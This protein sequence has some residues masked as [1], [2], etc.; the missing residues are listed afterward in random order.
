MSKTY[1]IKTNVGVNKQI[2]VNLEQDF[3]FLEILSLKFRPEDIYP[4]S[5]SDFGLVTGRVIANGGYGVPNAK[6]SIFIPLS[7][8][9]ALNPIISALYPYK[10]ISDINEDGYRYNLLPYTSQ[11]GGH[12]PTGTFPSETDVLINNTLIE[13]YDK[14]Y[15]FTVKTNDS[16]DYMIF[17]VPLGNQTVVMDLDLSDMG[18]FSLTPQDLIRMGMATESQVDGTRFRA[19]ENIDSL[20]QIVNKRIDISV[21]SFWGQEDVC[22]TK[23]HRLDFDLRDLG[24]EI[25]PTAVFMGSIISNS[26]KSKIN[27]NCKPALEGGNLCDLITGPGEILAIRQTIFIDSDNRPVLEEYKLENAGRVIDESGTWLT[28]L[29]MNL[30]Y[31]ITNEFGELIISPTPT[32]G[33]PTSA[34]YRFKIKWQQPNT[35]DEGVKRGYFLVPNI[36]ESWDDGNASAFINNGPAYELQSNNNFVKSYAF[37][38]DWNDYGMTGTTTPEGIIGE[39]MILDAINCTDRFFLFKYKK[40]Y[41]VAQ[42]IDQ[43]SNGN[44]RARFIGIKE[45]TDN[46]CETENNKFPI[47]DGVRNFN[48][49]YFVLSFFLYIITALLLFLIA[50]IHFLALI[51]RI[52]AWMFNQFIIP[53]CRFL[54]RLPGFSFDCP[55][56]IELGNLLT[57]ALPVVT[58]P[59]CNVCE[60]C[61]Q[62]TISTEDWVEQYGSSI[63]NIQ[64]TSFLAGLLDAENL[65]N[66]CGL[67][68]ANLNGYKYAISGNIDTDRYWKRTPFWYNYD[69]ENYDIP[70]TFG[71]DLPIYEN[72]NRFNLK[73]K[74]FD[75]QNESSGWTGG[76][77]FT[78]YGQNRISVAVEPDRPANFNKEHRDNVFILLVDPTNLAQFT[79]GKMISFQDLSQSNDTNVGNLL[80]NNTTGPRTVSVNYAN[81]SDPQGPELSQQYEIF[82]TGV[83]QE[84]LY[85]TD[86]EYFQVLTG[87]TVNDFGSLRN[88]LAFDDFWDGFLF[89]ND[90]ANV[91]QRKPNV[92]NIS[93]TNC[94]ISLPT[95]SFTFPDCVRAAAQ[96]NCGNNFSELCNNVGTYIIADE[97]C[98]SVALSHY[99]SFS[100]MGVVIMVRGVDANSERFKIKYGLGKIFGFSNEN[101][102][103]IQGDYKL[104]IPIK[105]RLNLPRHN[106]VT[107]NLQ[108]SNGS[109]LF[110]KTFYTQWSQNFSSY[111]TSA[112]TFYSAL[113]STQIN[114]F[115]VDDN[116]P[117]YTKL[118]LGTVKETGSE[119][120]IDRLKVQTLVDGYQILRA[121]NNAGYGFGAGYIEG[122]SFIYKNEIAFYTWGGTCTQLWPLQ[123]ANFAAE[124]SA[125]INNCSN[126]EFSY[127]GGANTGGG[128]ILPYFPIYFAPSYPRDGSM[129]MQVIPGFV[130]GTED[131]LVFRSDR[132]PTSTCDDKNLNNYFAAQANNKFCF[133]FLGDDGDVTSA[134]GTETNGSFDG[135]NGFGTDL[136]GSN[137][138]VDSILAS[139]SCDSL[140]DLDCYDGLNWQGSY[141]TPTPNSDCNQIGGNQLVRNGC[142]RLVQR[143]VIDLPSD[144]TQIGEWAGRVRVNLAACLNIF[145]HVFV[146]SWINGTLYA[147]NIK[148]NRFFN[149][150]NQPYSS[151]CHDVTILH[152]ETN[153][154][155]YRSSPFN[156]G[157]GQ[158]IGQ[159]APP[160]GVQ[161]K[162]L[163]FPTTIIDLGPITNFINEL[164]IG[165]NYQG[166]VAN[167]LP[168]TSYQDITEIFL[169][170][171]VS[172]Q[173]NSN[174][175]NEAFSI[176]QN[177]G[178]KSFFKNSRGNQKDRIDGDYIQT[179]QIN[180]QFGVL[181]YSFDLYDDNDF[182]ISTDNNG[183]PVL[184]LFFKSNRQMRDL[185]T[186]K[187]L[188]FDESTNII[189]VQ[190]IPTFT[191]QVPNYTWNINDGS[192]YIFGNEDNDWVTNYSQFPSHEYQAQDRLDSSNYFIGSNSI[193]SAITG[194]ITNTNLN[195]SNN[196]SIVSSI[197]GRIVQVGSPW[198]FYFGLK[199]GSSAIDKFYLRYVD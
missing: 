65:T 57:L 168:S 112:H 134:Y 157:S 6:I 63:G 26:E 150:Q 163:L 137:S 113:D 118:T 71:G 111:T 21:E 194:Y 175:L 59:D 132:L 15:K 195:G 121:G 70:G 183:N 7:D 75:G 85:P 91:V 172:R 88:P 2:Q 186:P 19:S 76:N 73:D 83:T 90:T 153:E 72:I 78:W 9:D 191:Q 155:F 38:L 18:P 167:N 53:V 39:Q 50:P 64:S 25:T 159:N 100:G 177:G 16:G 47:T 124:G 197:S 141:V 136:A 103:I 20:P 42:L 171:M 199:R 139:F 43:Y 178:A 192:P 34:K 156:Y 187:R 169:M 166:Y 133:F 96:S 24:I 56:P 27:K 181:G 182:F 105:R 109:M 44:N 185:I 144:F 4:R 55:E 138:A 193:V 180:S 23:I 74:Y 37:S 87:L 54:N 147:F 69:G 33:I 161:D 140:V 49:I 107:Y 80:Y 94:T 123:S 82:P 179:V 5:C 89:R 48:I 58:Y 14:Y 95:G 188:I 108:A 116:R 114:N 29:P 125:A 101:D 41:T 81:P 1:R 130:P 51:I 142:Y 93:Q 196:S 67:T 117:L 31:V 3:D 122:G 99:D 145:S 77:L 28:D 119:V 162:Q 165:S 170:F 120:Q 176:R 92:S 126:I 160:T 190:N 158:F 127:N 35:L 184:G 61:N 84:Y 131:Y 17:G 189:Q 30:D 128:Q 102:I 154:Y 60:N 104:N 173:L 32:I 148:N 135:S 129:T 40:I 174:F 115:I 22:Q 106:E 62:D 98:Q 86:I 8:S 13:I 164:I 46:R 10:S 149:N 52:V 151:Y 198:Y 146:N 36:K 79:K 68:G 11:H 143:A 45:I 152:P 97:S 110:S 12:T 66:P